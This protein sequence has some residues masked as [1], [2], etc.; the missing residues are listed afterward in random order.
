[1]SDYLTNL[2]HRAMK[3]TAIK[4]RFRPFYADPQSEP[5][6]EVFEEREI[7]QASP[8]NRVAGPRPH[9]VTEPPLHAP[10]PRE[11]R[12]Q[13]TSPEP[14]TTRIS[15]TDQGLEEAVRFVPTRTEAEPAG[16]T[17]LATS[18][19]L[20]ARVDAEPQTSTLDA[21]SEAALSDSRQEPALRTGITPASTTFAPAPKLDEHQAQEDRHGE[22]RTV[23]AEFRTVDDL[24]PQATDSARRPQRTPSSRATA[25]RHEE[26]QS[27]RPHVLGQNIAVASESLAPAN[28]LIAQAAREPGSRTDSAMD[29]EHEAQANGLHAPEPREGWRLRPVARRQNL[30]RPE[31]RDD[32]LDEQEMTIEISIGRIDIRAATAPGPAERRSAGTSP[33]KSSLDLYLEKQRAGVRA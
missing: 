27:D 12:T 29:G 22:L 20:V 32:A 25:R 15:R 26:S 10:A 1:M 18:S 24:S 17:P 16:E 2:A 4:P 11:D 30:R 13:H 3:P 21:R 33:G 6:Q 28:S 8:A 7:E 19:A 31:S 14:A 5:V 9:S 23:K